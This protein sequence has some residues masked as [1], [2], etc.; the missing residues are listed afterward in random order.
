MALQPAHNVLTQLAN[1]NSSCMYSSTASTTPMDQSFQPQSL[2]SSLGSQALAGASSQKL[3]RPTSWQ[4]TPCTSTPTCLSMPPSHSSYNDLSEALKGIM[5]SRI[6]VPS[7]QSPSPSLPSSLA[8]SSQA[9]SLATP[10]STPLAAL[11]TPAS[12][13]AGSLQ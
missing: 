9:L 5:M 11:P 8:S 6:T 12:Y 7:S 4:S 2:Q 1:D 3:S 10:Q 13:A